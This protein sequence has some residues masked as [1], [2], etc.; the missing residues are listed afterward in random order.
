MSQE[1]NIS[2]NT[3]ELIERF[4]NNEL[5]G[6]PLIDFK[7]KLHNDKDFRSQVDFVKNIPIGV[8]RAVLKE[9]IESFHSELQSQPPL[10]KL[11][12]TNFFLKI[13]V[14]ASLIICFGLLFYF[15]QSSPNEKLYQAYYTPDPGLPTVMSST[16]EYEFYDAMVDYKRKNYDFAIS[17]W[18]ALY[19]KA[20]DNDTLNYFL[21][22]AWMASKEEEKS[23]PYLEQVTKN[24]ESVFQDDARFYLALY[25]VKNNNIELAKQN[26]RGLT[27][28]KAKK[29]LEK[30]KEL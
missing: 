20:P 21:G 28:D 11:H 23:F 13:A 22:M 6:Q 2:Q 25:H 17:K 18:S 1:K 14:A 4:L 12:R 16:S 7:K 8:E 29:L 19:Q 9:K 15:Y 26:L 3:L 10:I 5:Q 30:L 27:V 24:N